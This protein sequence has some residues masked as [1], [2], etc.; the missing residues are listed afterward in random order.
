MP[1]LARMSTH[2]T[3]EAGMP[4]LKLEIEATCG[5]LGILKER[6]E[7]QRSLQKLESRVNKSVQHSIRIRQEKPGVGFVHV[8]V[9][10]DEADDRRAN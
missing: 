1:A 10:Q 5:R 3:T 6:E 9:T 2:P 7:A 4:I 8:N